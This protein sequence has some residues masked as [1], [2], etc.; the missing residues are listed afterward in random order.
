MCKGDI[1]VI[2]CLV[3]LMEKVECLIFYIGGGVINFGL[4]VSDSLCELVDVMGFLLILILMGLGVYLVLGKNWIG[5][6]G[7]YGFY[8]VNMVMYDCDLMIVVGVWFDDCIIGCVVD[9]SFGL[10]KV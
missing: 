7:M 10:V 9:F 3:E 6:L 5:M 4:E 1:V 8:E 2:I